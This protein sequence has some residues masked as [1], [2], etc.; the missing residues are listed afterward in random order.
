VT[1]CNVVL[2]DL[3]SRYPASIG[4]KTPTEVRG[5]ILDWAAVD[6]AGAGVTI[7]VS[8]WVVHPDDD[9]GTLTLT[10]PSFSGLSTRVLANGGTDGN[11]Y[12][13]VNSVTVSDGRRFE[14]TI[15]V[16]VFVTL[17]LAA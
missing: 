14:A 15:V 4:R 11:T 1:D 6:C 17:A 8:A 9:D 16:P 12:R 7:T 5:P 2:V 3:D 10:S 13:L